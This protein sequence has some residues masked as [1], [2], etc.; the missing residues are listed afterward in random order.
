MG[1]SAG[2]SAWKTAGKVFKKD[3]QS[4]EHDDSTS[5]RPK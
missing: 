2:F 4:I 5:T 3:D 1:R